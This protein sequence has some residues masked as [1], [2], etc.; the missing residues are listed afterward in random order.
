M[1]YKEVTPLDVMVSNELKTN[2][3][4]NGICIHNVYLKGKHKVDSTH[5]LNSLWKASWN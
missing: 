2:E 4:Q 3:R 1:R 5:H